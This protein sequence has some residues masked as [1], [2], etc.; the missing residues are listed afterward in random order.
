MNFPQNSVEVMLRGR[1]ERMTL[2]PELEFKLEFEGRR[3][4]SAFNRVLMDRGA[5]AFVQVSLGEEWD[6]RLD[7][8]AARTV[9]HL[10]LL[11]L[12]S[13]SLRSHSFLS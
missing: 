9:F 8:L 4:N 1:Y 6:E 3:A 5:N 7:S 2:D 13:S 12:C 11:V 10:S